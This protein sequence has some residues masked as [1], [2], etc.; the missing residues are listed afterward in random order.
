MNPRLPHLTHKTRQIWGTQMDLSR[1]GASVQT[2]AFTALFL[3]QGGDV[4]HSPM[5][6]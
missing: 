1:C 5:T 2:E 6:L 4:I 3:A